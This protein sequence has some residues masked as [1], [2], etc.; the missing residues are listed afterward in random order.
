MVITSI[1]LAKEY[2]E[3]FIAYIVELVKKSLLYVIIAKKEV[4]AGS[5]DLGKPYPD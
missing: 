3:R 5:R 1:C 4:I 2:M